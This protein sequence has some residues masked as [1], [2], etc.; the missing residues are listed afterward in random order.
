MADEINR[1]DIAQFQALGFLQEANRLF[2]H[3]HGLALEIVDDDSSMRLEIRDCRD[4]PQGPVFGPGAR[5]ELALVESVW[6]R[7]EKH[8]AHRAKLFGPFG[9][10]SPE[11]LVAPGAGL[12]KKAKTSTASRVSQARCAR[13]ELK[14]RVSL[15]L[16]TQPA[17]PSLALVLPA[18][19]SAPRSSP[20]T[21]MGQSDDSAWVVQPP[22]RSAFGRCAQHLG[23]IPTCAFR[24]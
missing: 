1:M 9:S 16:L 6:R 8:A 3:P 15:V 21:L 20:K 13:A 7:R 10:A 22:S 12:A 2:F 17:S 14:P 11:D 18:S 23:I 19:M 5:V 24:I 4:D